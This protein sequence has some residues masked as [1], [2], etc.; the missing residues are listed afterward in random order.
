MSIRVEHEGAERGMRQRHKTGGSGMSYETGPD[1]VLTEEEIRLQSDAPDCGSVVFPSR[2]VAH[3]RTALKVARVQHQATKRADI[4]K[5]KAIENPYAH[6]EGSEDAYKHYGFW[7]CIQ[8][9][10][11]ALGEG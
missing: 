8:V 6:P 3:M 4:E 7:E 11:K 1:G 5:V 10:L 9:V 2:Q